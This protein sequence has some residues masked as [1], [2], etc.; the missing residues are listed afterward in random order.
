MEV[1]RQRAIAELSQSG[2]MVDKA[3]TMPILPETGVIRPG[4]V[5][6]FRDEHQVHRIGIVRSTA[7]N[8]TFP[9]LTQSLKVQCHA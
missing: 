5:L 1:A 6:D 2:R 9:V 4:A 3:L 7:I 8:W